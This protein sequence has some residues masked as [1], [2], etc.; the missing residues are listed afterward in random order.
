MVCIYCL[1]MYHLNSR[2]IGRLVGR[3]KT[4][5]GHIYTQFSQQPIVCCAVHA[6]KQ[7]T[8]VWSNLHPLQCDFVWPPWHG[9]KHRWRPCRWASCLSV[10]KLRHPALAASCP[11]L[12]QSCLD[13]YQIQVLKKFAD[14]RLWLWA[15]RDSSICTSI[16]PNKPIYWG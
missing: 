2:C 6:I 13:G 11:C 3:L 15:G 5:Q 8:Q 4:E 16:G 9:A 10:F 14:G 12:V 1:N 7:N